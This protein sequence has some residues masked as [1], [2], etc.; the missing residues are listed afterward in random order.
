MKNGIGRK[1]NKSRRDSVATGNRERWVGLGNLASCSE[2]E[3]PSPIELHRP[4]F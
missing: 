4:G 3:P 1:D 2:I